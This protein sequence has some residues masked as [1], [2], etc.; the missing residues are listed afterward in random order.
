M[1]TIYVFSGLGADER[2]FQKIDF[3]NHKVIYINWLRPFEN[4][5]LIKYS[6]RITEQ[7][8]EYNPILIGISFGGIVAQEVAK[9]IETEKLILL[10]TIES[11]L[12]L[13]MYLRIFG[14][15]RIDKLIPVRILKSHNF[16]VDYFFGVKTKE[17]S[18]ILKNILFDTDK[19]FI[20]WA[21]R[22]IALWNPDVENRFRINKITIH[23]TKDRV[24]PKNHAKSY[25]YTVQN[26][27]HFFT[28]TH[29]QEISEI[30]IKEI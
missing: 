28:L 14:N 2:V 8:K 24:L 23:G 30:L 7:I 10:A 12:D 29:A 3:G 11:R 25:N 5:N 6:T 20:K 9:Q 4:E 17:N 27:G 15:L 18:Q 21:L 19:I 16:I 26:G 1:K 13:P 22:Q